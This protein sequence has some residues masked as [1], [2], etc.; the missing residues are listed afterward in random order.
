MS[1]FD[2]DKTKSKEY[3]D[4]RELN[5]YL[6]DLLALSRQMLS[7][8]ITEQ[9]ELYKKLNIDKNAYIAGKRI[10]DLYD[11][12]D[13]IMNRLAMSRI[14]HFKYLFKTSAENLEILLSCTKDFFDELKQNR[15][16]FDNQTLEF[17]GRYIKYVEK[18]IDRRKKQ[19]VKEKDGISG[20]KAIK[21]D[22]SVIDKFITFYEA[23]EAYIKENYCKMD[24]TKMKEIREF[25]YILEREKELLNDKNHRDSST[26][27]IINYP[28]A[29]FAQKQGEINIKDEVELKKIFGMKNIAKQTDKIRAMFDEPNSLV[30]LKNRIIDEKMSQND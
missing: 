2:W 25:I 17:L 16:L 26:F 13:E 15:E 4:M 23:N 11:S 28:N 21:R 29:Y 3:K 22:I 1:K 14:R 9:R 5:E 24:S 6:F 10:C 20:E 30:Y 7:S 8:N 12:E 27:N 18:C 19:A